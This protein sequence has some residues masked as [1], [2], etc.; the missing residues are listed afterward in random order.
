[1]NL[2]A[3]PVRRRRL[4]PISG[5]GSAAALC[6]SRPAQRSPALRPTCSPSRHATSSP[7]ASTASLPPLLLRLLPGGT[8]S[9]R[10]GLSPIVV[11]REKAPVLCGQRR[12]G[13]VEAEGH[14]LKLEDNIVQ[15]APGNAEKETEIVMLMASPV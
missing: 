10:A 7:E 4:S 5:G 6:V 9:S 15:K 2:F 11:R 13:A 14:W 1:M 8:T 12:C 3:P